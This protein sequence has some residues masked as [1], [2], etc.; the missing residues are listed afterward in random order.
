MKNNLSLIFNV[1][2]GIAVV[3]LFVLVLTKKTEYKQN[4]DF[5]GGSDSLYCAKLPIAYVNIDSLLLGYQFAKDA[6]ESL[7]KEQ[8]DSRLQINT[9]AN[10]LQN[11]MIEFQRKLEN[12]AFLSRQRAED[13][14]A[15]LMRKQQEL[16]DLDARLTQ[17]LMQKQQKMSEELRDTINLVLS[18]YNANKRYQMILSNSLNDNILHADKAYDIT[19]E[20]V[21]LLNKRFSAKK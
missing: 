17:Q 7:I 15:R 16:Q 3:C 18:T 13:E 19:N 11:E 4:V 2:L 5:V 14:Q 21:D 10:Q 8:E 20:I 6:N 12:N 1:V 9:K